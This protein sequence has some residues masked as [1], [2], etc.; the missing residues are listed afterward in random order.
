M[1]EMIENWQN[2][3]PSPTDSIRKSNFQVPANT[4]NLTVS[5]LI[6]AP[7]TQSHIANPLRDRQVF[8]WID[9]VTIIQ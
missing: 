5:L 3:C 2:P 9:M 8:Q 4:I 1:R 7:S 6:I